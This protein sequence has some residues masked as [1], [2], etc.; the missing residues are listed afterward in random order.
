MLCVGKALG[1]GLPVSACIGRDEVMSAWAGD[2]LGGEALHTGTFYGHPLGCAAALAA[3]D[4]IE[5]EG[6]AARALRLHDRIP[7]DVGQKVGRGLLA[8]IRFDRPV[9]ELLERLLRRGFLALP[10]GADACTLQLLPP[11]SI[12]E[13]LLDAF[14][15]VLRVEAR[16]CM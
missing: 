3:L 14:A 13:P 1:G 12:A 5:D 15:D 9:F 10:C 4:V 8:G 2:T 11:L 7:D 16:A 6:L